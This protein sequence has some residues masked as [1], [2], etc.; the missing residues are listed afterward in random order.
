MRNRLIGTGALIAAAVLFLAVNIISESLFRSARIDLTADGLYTLSEGTRKVLGNLEEPVT[1]RFFFSDKAATAYPGVKSYGGR[2]RDLLEEYVGL[3]GGKLR[4]EVIDPEPFTEAEDQAVAFGLKA[5]TTSDGDSLYFGL[6]GTN[7]LDD[8]QVIPFFARERERFLE[9][10]LTRLIY[11]LSH[12]DKTVIGL[13]TSLPLQYGAGGI[14]GMLRGRSRP[15][16]IYDRLRQLFEVRTLGPR[17]DKIDDDIDLLLIVD[18]EELDD[19]GLYAIDQFVLRGGRAMIFVDPH[20]EMAAA[21]PPAPGMPPAGGALSSDLPKLFR[22][23]GFELEAG[24]VVADRRFAQKVTMSNDDWRRVKDYVIWL[25]V[26][27]EGLSGDDVV[28][29]DLSLVNFG[30]AGHL[31]TLEGAT[32]TF[33]P[34][35]TSSKDAMLL[36]EK[37]ISAVPDPDALLR[38]FKPTGERYVI[39]ARI[40][41]EVESAFPDGPPKPADDDNAAADDS[42]DKGDAAKDADAADKP[43][44]PV[45]LAR[46]KGPIHVIV[47]ADSDLLDDRF[48]A[49]V[50]DF[51]GQRLVVPIADNASFVINGVDQLAGSSDLIGLRSR[52]VSAR[53]FTVIEDIRREAEAKFLAEE[54][55][56]QDKLSAAE[57]RIAALQSKES[58]EGALLIT[59][60]QQAEI[61]AF[62]REVLE[63]RRQLREVQRNLRKDIDRLE[64][65]VRFINIGLVPLLI[66]IGTAG[67]ALWRRRKMRRA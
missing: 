35:I 34:L 60:E 37:D 30:T 11:G 55:R 66:M 28:T 5:A 64:A 44:E 14:Q 47:V 25:S 49:Q 67:L 46:S 62:R 20:S 59:P 17:L 10:D 23:W 36:D 12:P 43:A 26:P 42:A 13:L 7:T 51:L 15:N 52:G 45:H 4:L 57:D 41:G 48:W 16:V 3:A 2:V 38:D 18:P 8:Q 40:S 24:K 32:T 9:Y 63:T 58:G 56:L 19:Q 21:P 22:A 65:W 50:Q 61:D 33:E 39:A 31:A 1:L 6:V 29:G 53:P 54:K 27:K